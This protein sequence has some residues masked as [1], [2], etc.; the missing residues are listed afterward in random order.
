[1]AVLFVL[2]VIFV[3]HKRVPIYYFF[4]I[5]A[6]CVGYLTIVFSP[7]E[8]IKVSEI[9]ISALRSGFIKALNALE[10]PMPLIIVFAVLL[11]ISLNQNVKRKRIIVS[12]IFFLGALF[13][14]FIMTVASYYSGRCLLSVTVLLIISDANLAAELYEGKRHEIIASICSVILLFLVL[15]I[16]V[17]VNDIYATTTAMEKNEEYI[18][19]C[20]EN[21]QMDVIIPYVYPYTKYSASYY[22]L[23]INDVDPDSWPNSYIADYYGIDSIIGFQYPIADE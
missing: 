2:A 6:A 22:L 11:P 7:A 8:S 18:I 23:Y 19:K 13:A 9:S 12:I 10:E 17:A 21:G 20:R 14:N 15:S 4:C 3:Q 1:M 5:L 16:P